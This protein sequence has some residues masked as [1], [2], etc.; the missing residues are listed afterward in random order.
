MISLSH[1]SEG[2]RLRH[3]MK[4]AADLFIL[5]RPSNAGVPVPRPRCGGEPRHRLRGR[6][7]AAELNSGAP[8][9]AHHREID[10]HSFPA[11]GLSR[12][13]FDRPSVNRSSVAHSNSDRRITGD[14]IIFA[15]GE[16]HE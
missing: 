10:H 11:F 7:G 3:A 14:E 4:I 6:G 12:G 1:Q 2:G 15:F 13:H 9:G 5:P 16:S 8:L